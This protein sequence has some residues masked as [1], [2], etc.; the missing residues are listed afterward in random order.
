MFISGP[1][2]DLDAT[3][4]VGTLVVDSIA[5]MEFGHLA[6]S[7]D[8]GGRPY[9]DLTASAFYGGGESM[10]Q[11]S[12]GASITEGQYYTHAYVL[13]WRTGDNGWR[14]LFRHHD[15]CAVVQHNTK[16]LGFYA[17]RDGGGFVGFADVGVDIVPHQDKWEVLVVTGA[18]NS[19]TGVSGVS[20][21][22][23]EDASG[24]L[25]K[26]GTVNYV[27]CGSAYNAIGWP[28]QGPGKVARVVTWD[29]VLSDV[30]I[31]NLRNTMVP[32]MA[33]FCQGRG[34]AQGRAQCRTCFSSL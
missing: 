24:V 7:V 33:P 22:W 19:P 4:Q 26:R 9:W 21:F 14:T 18:G 31:T 32:G 5:G 13:K 20:T 30:E 29:R 10:L 28:G 27:C 16:N 15:C 6:T 8:G 11:R 2:F 3:Q 25:V 1:I 23:M 12:G 34:L 17:V